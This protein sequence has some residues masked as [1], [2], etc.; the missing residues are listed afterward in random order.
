MQHCSYLGCPLSI[1]FEAKIAKRCSKKVQRVLKIGNYLITHLPK[2]IWLAPNCPMTL[3]SLTSLGKSSSHFPMISFFRSPTLSVWL[4]SRVSIKSIERWELRKIAKAKKEM[5]FRAL[6]AE[7]SEDNRVLG[8]LL[9]FL[10]P[11]QNKKCQTFAG[12]LVFWIL[13]L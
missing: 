1:S 4:S 13:F 12:I 9:A 11:W 7:V 6:R 8:T 5:V 3:L 10:K 2:S